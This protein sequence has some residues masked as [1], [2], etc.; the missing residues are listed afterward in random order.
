MVIESLL[1]A[2]RRTPDKMAARDPFRQLTYQQLTT[3]SKAIRRLVLKATDCPRIGIMLPGTAAGLST[4]LGTL[5]AGK[6]TVPLNFLLQGPELKAVIADAGID[7]I[8]ST[9]HFASTLSGIPIRT[10]YIEQ[11]GLARRYFWEKLTRTPDPPR[12]SPD[13]VAAIVYTSGSTGR[14]KGVCLTY[15]N[16]ESNGRAAI[17]HLQLHPEHHL[18]GILPPFHVFGLTLLTFLPVM[19]GATVTFVPRFSAQAVCEALK[20]DAAISLLLGVPSM[21]AAIARLKSLDPSVFRNLTLAVSG[22][23]PLPRKIY[24]QMLDRTGLRLMEGYGMTETSP[25]IS[26]DLPSNHRVGTVGLPLPGVEIQVRDETGNPPPDGRTGE[27]CVRGP[28]VMKGYYNRPDETRAV[29]DQDGWLRTGDIVHIHEDGHIAITGRCK[30]L[31]IV[32][33]ENVYPREVE[34]VLEQH[35][36]V[37][38]AAVVGQTDSMRGEVIVAFVIPNETAEVTETDLRAFCRDRLAGFKVP[39]QIIIRPEL[40]RGPSGKILKRE[41]KSTLNT[42]AGDAGRTAA[43]P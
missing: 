23:E 3:L 40:P 16:V 20:T 11:L 35:P 41:L 4:L 14:P 8:I 22:G 15:T 37:R 34:S 24:D 33:G 36:A 9:T 27:L 18:L 25:V 2:A 5:W 7:L 17:Q 19:L 42:R 21:Y 12:V 43:G 38:E 28:L 13:D 32:G 29:I 1:D 30:D 31:I 6:V 26:C 10:L 39:R